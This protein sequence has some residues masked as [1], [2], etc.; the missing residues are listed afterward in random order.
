M[1][2]KHKGFTLI[3]LLVV[4]AIIGILA[5]ILLPALARAREAARRS[6]CANNLK[7]MGLVFKMYSNEWNERYP[8]LQGCDKWSCEG[9]GEVSGCNMNDDGDWTFDVYAVFPEYLTDF[10]VTRCPSDPKS[11]EENWDVIYQTVN[12][13]GVTPCPYAGYSTSADQSYL[14][15]GWVLDRCDIGDAA[16][17]PLID[18]GNGTPDVPLQLQGVF[19]SIAIPVDNCNASQAPLDDDHNLADVGLAG[20]GN[21]GGDMVY[22]LREGIERFMINDINN[23][24]ATAVAQ[25]EVP[26][27]WDI[28]SLFPGGDADFNHVPGGCNVLYMDGHVEFERYPSIKFPVNAYMANAILWASGP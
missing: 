7:Q 15:L 25:S 4:I 8:R 3:E 28:V 14:Y 5:A 26:I 27:M 21:G 17:P 18:L 12:N 2:A 10:H 9:I 6:S 22:R 20:H 23:P 13:A 24:A 19:Y 11:F 1:R 16:G